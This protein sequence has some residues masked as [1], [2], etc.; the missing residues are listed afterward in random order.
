MTH[1]IIFF[2][3][4]FLGWWLDSVTKIGRRK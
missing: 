4:F 2:A 3:G 1:A